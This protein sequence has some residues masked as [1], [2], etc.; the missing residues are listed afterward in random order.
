MNPSKLIEGRRY[1]YC[2]PFGKPIEVVKCNK[3]SVE[4]L[5]YN[6]E[7][8][9]LTDPCKANRVGVIERFNHIEIERYIQEML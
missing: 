8:E 2:A 5:N 6:A 4:G 9:V 1:K 3:I 7:F